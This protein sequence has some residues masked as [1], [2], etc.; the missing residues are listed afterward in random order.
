M[1][2][3]RLHRGSFVIEVGLSSV[4]TVLATALAISTILLF[5]HLYQDLL[6]HYLRGVLTILGDARV[7]HPLV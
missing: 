2:R 4:E 3:Q 1:I 7:R 5:S 6:L